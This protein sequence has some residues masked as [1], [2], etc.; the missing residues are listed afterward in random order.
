[1]ERL[2][3]AEEGPEA[4]QRRK[5]GHEHEDRLP[6]AGEQ[7][8]LADAGAMMGMA[9]K[10]MKI[11]D[12]TSAMSRP[13]KRSRT[14]AVATTRAAAAPRPCVKRESE[15]DCEIRREGRGEGADDIDAQ[16]EQQRDAAAEAVGQR[17]EDELREAEAEHVGA[18]TSCRSFS[19]EMPGFAHI[20]RAGSM[21][22]M[23]SALSAIRAAAR[24]MNSPGQ[25]PGLVSSGRH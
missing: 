4:D 16:P 7:Q 22:S 24:A 18:T 5:A 9:M 2:G 25:V 3:Q 10:T 17:P 8:Y 21:T 11:S 19:C 15:E 1:M 23:A 20:G 13:A 14:T 12:M 6:R